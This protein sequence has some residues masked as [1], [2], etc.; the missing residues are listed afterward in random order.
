MKNKKILFTLLFSTT[1]LIVCACNFSSLDTSTSVASNTINSLSSSKNPSSSKTKSNGTSS[2]ESSKMSSSSSEMSFEHEHTFSEKWLYNNTKHWHSA[3]CG[4]DIIKDEADHIF[5]SLV[6]EPTATKGGYTKYKCSVCDF[7]YNDDNTSPNGYTVTWKNYDGTIL[8]VDRHLKEGSIPSYDRVNPTRVEYN[9]NQTKVYKFTGWSPEIAPVTNDVEYV[10]QF[11][12]DENEY[13]EMRFC[14]YD[15][16]IIFQH[17]VKKGNTASVYNG[18]T[19]TRP[20]QA[21]GSTITEYTFSKWDKDVYLIKDSTTFKALFS[22]TT[23][24]GYKATFLDSDSTELYSHY[25]KEGTNARFEGT[26]PWSY[27]KEKVHTFIGWDKP[28]DNIQSDLIVTAQYRDI[29]R[30]QNGEFPQSVV[31]DEYTIDRLQYLED[32]VDENGY[33]E[34]NGEYYVKLKAAP[35]SNDYRFD[36]GKTITE[37]KNYYFKVEPIEWKYLSGTGENTMFVSKRIL[38]NCGFNRYFTG[39]DS[40]GYYDSSYH[41]SRIRQWLNED[42]LKIAFK[43]NSLITTTLVINN[44]DSTGCT[45]LELG[46]HGSPNTNDKVFLLSYKE[47]SDTKNGFFD[48]DDRMATATDYAK[49]N[50]CTNCYWTRSPFAEGPDHPNMYG[51]R[52]VDIGHLGKAHHENVNAKWAGAC[53]ALNFN[54]SE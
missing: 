33:M 51:M 24:T 47:L 16:S 23:F 25:F 49:A 50:G 20:Q 27:D 4:H 48:D 53:P 38:Y 11:T 19:P 32:C 9:M 1:S 26:I 36:N 45:A 2:E 35:Y 17:Y 3:T 46:N 29:P 12:Q 37:K 28:I 18:P 22:S 44:L 39:V 8:A 10:A 31:T 6:V 15:D 34:Y 42:F 54:F 30:T 52:Y 5:E 13:F 7:S 14:N 21:N 40:D 41:N 43:D